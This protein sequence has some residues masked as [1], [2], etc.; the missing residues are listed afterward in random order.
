MIKQSLLLLLSVAILTFA[1]C[2]KDEEVKPNETPDYIGK[3]Q[4]EFQDPDLGIVSSKTTLTLEEN[5]WDNLVETANIVDEQTVWS[6]LIKMSGELNVSGAIAT[7][8]VKSFAFPNNEGNLVVYSDTDS[9]F[10]E[11]LDE[12]NIDET[13][14][15]NIAVDGNEL[16]LRVDKNQDGEFT[17]DE[18]TKYT[19][20]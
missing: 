4:Y 14:F 18:I 20:I 11:K 13:I 19:K 9:N 7:L 3:W 16:S 5:T 2:T 12:Y 10:Q 8:K 1:S 17:E 15:Y 6:T